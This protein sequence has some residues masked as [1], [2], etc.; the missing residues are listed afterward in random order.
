MNHFPTFENLTNLGGCQYFQ[1]VPVEDVLLVPE[2]T[3][4]VINSPIVLVGSKTFLNGF[5]S[6]KTLSFEEKPEKRSSGNCFLTKISGFYPKINPGALSLF[7]KMVNR[8]F[9]ILIR[10]NNYYLRLAG[11]LEHP[12]EFRY[13]LST[14][15]DPAKRNG[16]L[17]EFYGESLEPAPFYANGQVPLQYNP[18]PALD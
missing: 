17:F 18:T 9:L 14:G 12:L 2:H 10:D 4:L 13:S 5:A 11:T 6:S 8:K 16:I 3:D 15:A 1:F 7:E